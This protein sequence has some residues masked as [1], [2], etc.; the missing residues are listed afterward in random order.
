MQEPE[1]MGHVETGKA[2]QYFPKAGKKQIKIGG[3][4]GT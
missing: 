2:L 3:E 4:L 1:S